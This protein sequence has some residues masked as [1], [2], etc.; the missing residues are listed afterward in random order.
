MICMS[1]HMHITKYE[2]YSEEL[3]A[4]ATWQLKQGKFIS[5]IR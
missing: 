5:N 3:R 1:K 4:A 2:Q